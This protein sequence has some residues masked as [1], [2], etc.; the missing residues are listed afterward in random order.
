[1]FAA[2]RTSRKMLMKT[3]CK[4]QR[5]TVAFLIAAGGLVIPADAHTVRSRP[6]SGIV[7][8]LDVHTRTVKLLPVNGQ[9]SRELALTCQTKFI[10]NQHFA[11]ANDLMVGTSAVFYYR[12]PFFGRPFVTKVV[13]SKGD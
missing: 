9:A 5:F 8:E 12:R 6:T 1:M 10:Q 13:W 2:R 4:T 7:E 11:P 3:S